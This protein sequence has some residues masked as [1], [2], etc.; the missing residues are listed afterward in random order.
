MSIKLWELKRKN[1][2]T[3][4]YSRHPLP[5]CLKIIIIK[6]FVGC[7]IVPRVIIVT[8]IIVIYYYIILWNSVLS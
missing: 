2:Q 7:L 6:H 8:I 3:N 4:Y 1:K 5:T